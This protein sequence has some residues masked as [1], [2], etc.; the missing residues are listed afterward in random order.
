MVAAGILAMTLASATHTQAQQA[1]STERPPALAVQTPRDGQ[2]D[3]DFEHGTWK[4]H[5]SRRVKR[6]EGSNDWVEFDGTSV[7]KPIWEGKGNIEQFETDSGNRHIEGLTLRVYNPQT[8]QW[9]IY[10]ASSSDPDLGTPMTPMIG[11]FNADGTGEFYDQEL[12]KGRSVIVRFIWSRITPTSAHFEQ[13]F[14][15]DGGKTWE[16]N[17]ITDQT[18]VQDGGEK[19]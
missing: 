13:A 5:L 6:L 17:W 11:Q 10:W 16:V 14:S 4:I 18:R 1:S 9:S 15:A 2:H 8:H 3:F 12:W 7:T 19:K